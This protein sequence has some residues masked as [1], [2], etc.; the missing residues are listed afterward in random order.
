MKMHLYLGYA[1]WMTAL[2]AC[3]EASSPAPLT[4]PAPASNPTPPI[5]VTRP[6][7]CARDAIADRVRDVFCT[8]TLPEIHSLYE[9]QTLL[10]IDPPRP[11]EPPNLL[12]PYG[13][14]FV[15]A[16]GHSTALAGRLVSPINPRVIVLGEQVIT[17]FQRGVQQ[18]EIVARYAD[19]IAYNFYLLT[20][21]QACNA[22]ESGC[23]NGD[24]FTPRIE[25]DWTRIEIRDDEELKNSVAD[26]R[27]CHQRARPD[28]L[29]LMRELKAPWAHFFEPAP[30]GDIGIT[31]PGPRNSDLMLDYLQAKGDELYGSAAVQD[32][33]PT[34]ASVLQSVVGSDQPLLFDSRK[35][36]DERWPYGPDGFP[37]EPNPSPTWE[38]A[39]ASFKRGEQLA[40]PYLERRVSDAQK[41]A[42]LTAAYASYRAGDLPADELPD[43]SDIF[44]D[45]PYLR[46]RMGLSVE[47]DAAPA[48]ALIQACGSCHNDVLDQTI[49]RAR[50]NIDLSRL[51]TSELEIA[52]DRIQRPTGASGSMPPRD[53]RQLDSESRA[54]LLEYLRDSV[55]ARPDEPQLERAARL[56]MAGNLR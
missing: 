16:L 42:Q 38:N 13:S 45:D 11:G 33:P 18:L 36:D 44:P 2:V 5:D 23:G 51:D 34:A 30:Q 21:E 14:K 48:D 26:C 15:I 27:Q 32:I 3:A 10:R 19:R 25:S 8:D 37:A 56:G 35:I 55:R 6:A 9:L 49:S 43:L 12:D 31:L 50:F 28:N 17:A 53:A 29:L 54:R 22:S 1:A 24:L 41:Q 47:P 39:Y 40:L 46:A 20:F 52:I 7:F 4:E